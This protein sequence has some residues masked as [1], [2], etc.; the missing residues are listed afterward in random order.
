MAKK[1]TATS[2]KKTST[3]RTATSKSQRSEEQLIRFDYIK[4]NFFRVIRVDGI[5]GGITVKGDGIQMALFSERRPIPQSEEHVVE[6]GNKIGKLKQVIT[7][8][9]TIIREVEVE[10]ILPLNAAKALHSWLGR[11]IEEYES[12]V[13]GMNNDNR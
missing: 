7:R 13:G 8:E 6:G 2:R 1:K 3:K 10:A 11:Q 12:I 5:H 4:S 9:D